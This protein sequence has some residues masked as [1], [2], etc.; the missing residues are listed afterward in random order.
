MFDQ[1]KVGGAEACPEPVEGKTFMVL[2][3][4][5]WCRHGDESLC[6]CY[7]ADF[8]RLVRFAMFDRLLFVE[9]MKTFMILRKLYFQLM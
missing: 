6:Y 7:E 8:S 3:L 5:G 2:V 1:V 9:L 4:V